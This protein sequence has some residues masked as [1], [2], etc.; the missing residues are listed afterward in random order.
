MTTQQ[1][2]DQ[3]VELFKQGKSPEIQ[4]TF[5]HTDVFSKEPEH[6]AARGVQILTKGFEAVQ[7]KG[8]ATRE[9]IQEIHS[10]HCSQ[11]IV[12]GNYFSVAMGRDL[13]FKNGQ[14]FQTNEI[15]VFEVKDGKIMSETFFY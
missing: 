2:A 15:A 9:T 11:P 14:R 12:G 5:Y 10:F 7:A 3:Y 6:A 1:V 13:T 8:K 4:S